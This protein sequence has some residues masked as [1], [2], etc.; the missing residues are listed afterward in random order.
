MSSRWHDVLKHS[1]DRATGRW[2]GDEENKLKDAVQLRSVKEWGAVASIWTK[3]ED[4][5]LKDAVQL[6]GGNDWVA[7]AALAWVQI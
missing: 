3:G 1:I 5:K 4:S 2:T 7:I 6:H